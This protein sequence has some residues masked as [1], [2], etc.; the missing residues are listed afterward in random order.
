MAHVQFDL[1]KSTRDQSPV[2]E[3]F[4]VQPTVSWQRRLWLYGAAL[5]ASAILLFWGQ[6]QVNAIEAAALDDHGTVVLDEERRLITAATA[7]P[8]SGIE[9]AER[10]L[11]YLTAE[12]LELASIFLQAGAAKDPKYRDA[13]VY[14]GY[15]ELKR[16]D[17]LWSTDSEEAA[18]R[19]RTAATLL[20]QARST[21]PIHGYTFELLEV[22][23][24]NLGKTELASEAKEKAALF[25][26][27]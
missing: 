22:A 12:N 27:K 16:A 4:A 24:T 2:R 26:S 14:A 11:E 23:Y 18:R 5:V 15:T 1:A 21:D 9:L 17:G 3:R 25:A 8:K 6:G 10:G 7:G 19:T 20:E 13:A